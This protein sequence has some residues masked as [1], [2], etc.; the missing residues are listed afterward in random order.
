MG[1]CKFSDV[2]DFR[3]CFHINASK[4][5]FKDPNSMMKENVF[6]FE[7]FC[8]NITNILI[9]TDQS[10]FISWPC[11]FPSSCKLIKC[12]ID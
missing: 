10:S 2:S 12:V 9:R 4:I 3:F 6:W 5:I 1:G 11:S 7:I 8:C